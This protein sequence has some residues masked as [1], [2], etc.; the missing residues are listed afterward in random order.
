MS[1][2]CGGWRAQIASQL[3]VSAVARRSLPTPLAHNYHSRSLSLQ[4]L[5]PDAYL[6]L[7]GNGGLLVLLGVKRSAGSLAIIPYFASYGETTFPLVP[8][9]LSLIIPA[10]C[11]LPHAIPPKR[12]WPQ[13]AKVFPTRLRPLSCALRPHNPLSPSSSFLRLLSAHNPLL[14]LFAAIF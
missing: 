7:A 2:R 4:G 1:D 6:L 12:C 10:S 14:P 9:H 13:V 5:M 8:T 11:L 3:A